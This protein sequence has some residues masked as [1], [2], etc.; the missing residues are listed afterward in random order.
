MNFKL[1]NLTFFLLIIFFIFLLIPLQTKIIN[2]NFDY[3]SSVFLYPLE[4]FFSFFIIRERNEDLKIE[5]QNLKIINS[6]LNY[7]A[8]ENAELKKIL[9]LHIEDKYNK[10]IVSS[11]IFRSPEL[12]FNWVIINKGE[13]NGVKENMAV[14]SSGGGAAG[15]VIKVFPY[16]SKVRLILDE[17]SV[18]PVILENGA[19]GILY[20]TGRN[21]CI[22]KYIDNL[23]KIKIGEKVFTS[24][25]SEYFPE[26]ELIG[27]VIH[28]LS[29]D[30]ALFKSVEV[31]P[32][33]DFGRLNF[34]LVIA[35]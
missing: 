22:I 19:M 26:G 29:K 14:I 25:L 32:A 15:K 11:V 6:K 7:L 34:V 16:S 28:I 3:F 27:E 9:N 30:Q 13:I 23:S 8:R 21:T 18:L 31:K 10:S 5:N 17:R 12:W 20:G 35:K 2:F 1:K 24:S 33:S 4:N